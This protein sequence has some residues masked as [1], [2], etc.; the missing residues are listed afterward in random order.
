[1]TLT[2]SVAVL[3]ESAVD[4]AVMIT[5][6]PA[7]TASGAVKV[8]ATAL[9]VCVG[10]KEPQAPGLPQI[11]VQSTP[12]AAV[13]LLTA[14][15]KGAL[16]FSTIEPDGTPVVIAMEMGAA[17]DSS[18]RAKTVTGLAEAAACIMTWPVGPAGAV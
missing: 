11:T 16:V 12:A 5:V 14:A 6:L 4:V 3:L 18:A 7:G 2:V 13:S 8:V 1:M 10:E 17:I 15:T 9:D